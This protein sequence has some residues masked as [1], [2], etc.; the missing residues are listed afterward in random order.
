MGILLIVNKNQELQKIYCGVTKQ[1]L[2]EN[3]KK[4]NERRSSFHDNQ[5]QNLKN[6]QFNDFG[7]FLGAKQA[8]GDTK[9]LDFTEAAG[10]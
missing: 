3:R 8:T 2:M 10:A 6:N 1:E 4:V 9:A 5:L 7:T